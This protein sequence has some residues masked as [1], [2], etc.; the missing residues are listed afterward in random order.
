MTTIADHCDWQDQRILQRQREPAHATLAPYADAQ[1]A[2]AGERGASP[3]FQ[4]LN[5]AW[6]F[7]YLSSP[8][9]TPAEFFAPGYPTDDW[10]TLPVPSDW[11]MHGYGKPHYTQYSISFSAR[12]RSVQEENP[13]GLLSPQLH[14]APVPLGRTSKSSWCSKAWTLRFMS[15]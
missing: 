14:H 10:A 4:L 8:A 9:E 1:S 12:P 2:L 5:G 15:G 7:R 3:F 6:R 11:Q 13:V